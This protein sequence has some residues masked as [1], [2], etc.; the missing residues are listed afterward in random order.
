MPGYF[1]GYEGCLIE[2]LARTLRGVNYFRPR[3][4]RP[5]PVRKHLEEPLPVRRERANAAA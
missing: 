2:A 4:C 1:G 3:P 5:V